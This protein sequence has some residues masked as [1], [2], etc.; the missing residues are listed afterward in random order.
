MEISGQLLKP[1]YTEPHL[2]TK[3]PGEGPAAHN[4]RRIVLLHLVSAFDVTHM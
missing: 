3:T 1:P 2:K 4:I